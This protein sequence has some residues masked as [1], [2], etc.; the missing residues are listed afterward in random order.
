MKTK[1]LFLSRCLIGL[2]PLFVGASLRAA[3]LTWFP[4]AALNEPRSSAAA[5]VTPSGSIMLFGGNPL[6]STNVL[7]YGSSDVQPLSSTRIAPGAVALSS[8][9]FFVYGG[10]ETTS[11][12]SVARNVLRY[13][14]V[15]PR[16]GPAKPNIFHVSP[17][18]SKRDV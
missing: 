11:S 14:P 4:G 17:L 7:I 12:H 10:E 18:S 1:L 2:T 15:S 9:R 5:V 16:P 6:G 8:G 13:N 3:P